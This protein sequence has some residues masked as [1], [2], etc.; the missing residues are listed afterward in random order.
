MLGGARC[1]VYTQKRPYCD[2]FLE[3]MSRKFELGV[4]SSSQEQYGNKVIEWL[5]PKGVIKYKYFR[6]ACAQDG[7]QTIKDLGKIGCDLRRT[8]LIDDKQC[9]P[10][11]LDNLILCKAFKGNKCDTQLL[12]LQT[13]LSQVDN[14]IGD[15][16]EWITL[17]HSH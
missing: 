8:I 14:E 5:D 13:L 4:F 17:T 7:N 11:H 2:Q 15:V 3:T 6:D 1:T 12:E 9:C 16:R 10:I